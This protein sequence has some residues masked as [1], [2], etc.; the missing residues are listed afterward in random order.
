MTVMS[1]SP[2][3][4]SSSAAVVSSS[5][6]AAVIVVVFLL[7]VFPSQTLAADAGKHGIFIAANRSAR[8]V[9][10]RPPRP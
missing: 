8:P 6:A 5:A 2:M 4:S 7:A 10:V 9:D 3:M 1:S